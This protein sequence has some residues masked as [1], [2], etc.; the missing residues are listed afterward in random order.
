MQSCATGQTGFG[1]LF[2]LSPMPIVSALPGYLGISFGDE[3]TV[4]LDK[5]P[6]MD[7]QNAQTKNR[8]KEIVT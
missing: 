3:K 8:A 7:R 2:I 6:T 1:A 5:F 4:V